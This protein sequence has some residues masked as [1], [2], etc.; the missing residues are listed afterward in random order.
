MI[1]KLGIKQVFKRNWDCS[2]FNNDH[3]LLSILHILTQETV[4][5]SPIKND[6]FYFE[7]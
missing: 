1:L 3:N 7:L 6:L 2:K 5:K 4:V